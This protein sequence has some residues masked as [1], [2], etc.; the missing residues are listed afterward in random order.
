MAALRLKLTQ[1]R[2]SSGHADLGRK[3]VLN[4]KQ[5]VET[6]ASCLCEWILKIWENDQPAIHPA[7]G[8]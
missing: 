6:L 8:L 7:T 3:G 1:K 2:S 4:D 5:D